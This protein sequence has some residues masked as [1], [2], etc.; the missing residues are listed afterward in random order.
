MSEIERIADERQELHK[1]HASTRR[2]SKH[3]TDLVGLA[4]ENAYAKAFNLDMDKSRKPGG[5]GGHDFYFQALRVDVKTTAFTGPNKTLP[6]EV[7]PAN[8]R[9]HAVA[10]VLAFADME[11]RVARLLGWQFF[12]VIRTYPQRTFPG[13]DIVNYMVPAADLL[14]MTTHKHLAWLADYEGVTNE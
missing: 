8:N 2:Y 6:V 14:P 7:A 4:G 13:R 11:R 3:S 9:P 10:Y 12:S 1:N 5:D